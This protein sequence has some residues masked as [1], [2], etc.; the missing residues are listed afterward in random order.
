MAG[1]VEVV[2]RDDYPEGERMAML[3]DHNIVIR[4]WTP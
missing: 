1:I 4:K 2:Y 3:L